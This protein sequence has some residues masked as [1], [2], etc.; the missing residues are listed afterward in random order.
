MVNYKS[1]DSVILI[2]VINLGERLMNRIIKNKN[3]YL[4]DSFLVDDLF[5][6]NLLKSKEEAIRINKS[7]KIELKKLSN[8]KLSALNKVGLTG[9]SLTLKVSHIEIWNKLFLKSKTKLAL[10]HL[11]D[12]IILILESLSKVFSKLEFFVELLKVLKNIIK[13]YNDHYLPIIYT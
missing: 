4:L 3:I 2:R 11:F 6:D 7:V 13:I 1:S 10:R 9:N 12:G 8:S 5:I